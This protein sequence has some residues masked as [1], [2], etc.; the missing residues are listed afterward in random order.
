M[1]KL[2]HIVDGVVAREYTLEA[3]RLGIGRRLDNDIRLDDATV[4]GQ[5]AA[6]EVRPNPYMEEYMEAVL[7]DLGSTNGTLVDGRT[8]KRHVLKPDD[9]IQIGTHRFKYVDESAPR[10]DE[11]RIL[12]PEDQD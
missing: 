3:G 8:V 11:T 1:A 7:E 5:H 9:V 4:S 2:L 10:L 6:I 12:L